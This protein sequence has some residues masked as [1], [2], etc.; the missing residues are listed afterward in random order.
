MGLLQTIA[1]MW[2]FS[3]SYIGDCEIHMDISKFNLG[4][5]GVQVRAVLTLSV[6]GCGGQGVAPSSG[7]IMIL[8]WETSSYQAWSDWLYLLV[9]GWGNED[10]HGKHLNTTSKLHSDTL[11]WWALSMWGPA[12][13]TGVQRSSVLVENLR[14]TMMFINWYRL[15]QQPILRMLKAGREMALLCDRIAER[16]HK[17]RKHCPISIAMVWGGKFFY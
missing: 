7:E 12:S 9:L 16:L 1:I 15:N 10:F 14:R 8:N 5:K 11:K 13:A 3:F 2:E 17:H 6:Q 4:V